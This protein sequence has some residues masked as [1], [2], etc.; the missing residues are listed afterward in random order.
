MTGPGRT[1][2]PPNRGMSQGDRGLRPYKNKPR[3]R[4]T[5]NINNMKLNISIEYRTNWGE[6]IV[7]CLG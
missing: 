3:L 4:L 5:Q 6:E 7:L 2:I 1:E